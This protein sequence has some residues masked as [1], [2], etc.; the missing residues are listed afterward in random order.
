MKSGGVG[1]ASTGTGLRFE[2]GSSLRTALARIAHYQ[3]RGEVVHF[4]GVRVARL[5]EK[6]RLYADYLTPNG[7]D[8][9]TILSCK[10]LPDQA[11]LVIDHSLVLKP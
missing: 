4:K 8:Y 6:N 10:L 5:L 9:R 2:D 7:V 3:V 11:L 1:G